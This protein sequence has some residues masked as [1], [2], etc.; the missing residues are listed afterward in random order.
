MRE[1]FSNE[2]RQINVHGTWEIGRLQISSEAANSCYQ[3]S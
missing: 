1:L 3:R 2:S